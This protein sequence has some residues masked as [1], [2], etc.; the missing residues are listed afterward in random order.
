[1]ALGSDPKAVLGRILRQGLAVVAAGVAGGLIVSWAVGRL[2]SGILFGVA[3]LDPLSIVL[4]VSVLGAAAVLANA[5]PA[6]RAAATDPQVVL[7]GD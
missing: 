5:I 3:P 1:M 2:I 6:S 4:V 7:R